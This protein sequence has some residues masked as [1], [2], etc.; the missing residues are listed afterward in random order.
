MVWDAQMHNA[1]ARQT[2]VQLEVMDVQA[3]SNG[4]V[5]QIHWDASKS[6]IPHAIRSKHAIRQA[7]SVNALCQLI[8][9]EI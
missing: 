2:N 5:L 9:S 4:V 3:A 8:Q 6:S 1:F 7:E